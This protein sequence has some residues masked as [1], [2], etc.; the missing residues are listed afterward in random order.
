MQNVYAISGK[1]FTSGKAFIFT[2]NSSGTNWEI[3]YPS[4]GGSLSHGVTT[5]PVDDSTF[6]TAISFVQ[7]PQFI[8]LSGN[9]TAGDEITCD[10]DGK[11]RTRTVSETLNGVALK[12]G[13]SGSSTSIISFSLPTP[14]SESKGGFGM[15]ASGVS[16]G[17]LA[18]TASNTWAART[19]TAGSGISISNGSGVSGNPTVSSTTVDNII[20]SAEGHVTADQTTT[21]G[22]L[23]D[24]TGATATITT[25]ASSKVLV[26][27]SFATSTAGA[28]GATNTL[29]LVVDGVVDS[30]SASSLPALSGAAQGGGFCRLVTGLS[31][32]SHT[33]KLQWFTS[34]STA[35]CRP[36]AAPNAE[37]A[38]ITI[39]ELRV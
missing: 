18:H 39:M 27:A 37:H 3:D 15:D 11:F 33:F 31:A 35:R 22:T 10:I 26:N 6:V 13:T 4:L 36:V 21:S 28:L 17:I 20:Q 7:G 12:S 19:I 32:A 9:V 38:S 16:T 34:T 1:T 5:Q 30:G 8:H 2:G 25:Q 24:L 29:A 14:F 23:V